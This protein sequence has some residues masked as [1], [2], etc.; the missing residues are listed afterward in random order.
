MS[1]KFTI[2]SFHKKVKE[3]KDNYYTQVDKIVS[4][5]IFINSTHEISTTKEIDN[6]CHV[7]THSLYELFLQ[8]FQS[9]VLETDSSKSVKKEEQQNIRKELKDYTNKSLEII[10]SKS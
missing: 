10:I 8:L 9:G 2:D 3:I 5:Y 1:E 6:I 7:A 4:N